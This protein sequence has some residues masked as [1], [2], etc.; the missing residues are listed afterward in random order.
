MTNARLE[1][2]NNAQLARTD[3]LSL[4]IADWRESSGYRPVETTGQA[5]RSRESV[6]AAPKTPADASATITRSTGDISYSSTSGF[7][8][9]PKEIEGVNQPT[10]TGVEAMPKTQEIPKEPGLTTPEAVP[11]IPTD[12][13]TEACENSAP[14]TGPWSNPEVQICPGPG[15]QS[16]PATGRPLSDTIGQ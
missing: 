3:G 1:S 12:P 4:S 6:V 5:T 15:I 16:N 14:G 7:L 2:F 13:I 10:A 11:P 8:H 9:I